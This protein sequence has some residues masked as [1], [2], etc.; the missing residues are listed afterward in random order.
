M[1]QTLTVRNF[2]KHRKLTIDFDPKVTTLVGPS[3]AG[4]SGIIRSLGLICLNNWNKA[5][6]RHGKKALKVQLIVDGKKI[7]REKGNKVNRY[8]FE[9]KELKR[10][11]SSGNSVPP[12]VADLLNTGQENFQKQ[13]DPHF[14]FS[15]TPGQVSKSL[16]KIVD[17]SVIDS[18]LTAATSAVK[19]TKNVLEVCEHRANQAEIAIGDLKWVPEFVK[20]YKQLLALAESRDS[21]AS[22]VRFLRSLIAN[23]RSHSATAEIATEAKLDAKKALGRAKRAREL[24]EQR[25]ELHKL[26]SGLKDLDVLLNTGVPDVGNL[27]YIRKSADKVAENRRELEFLIGELKKAE[28]EEC[29]TGEEVQHAT[30]ELNRSI[31][32]KRCPLCN[33]KLSKQSSSATSTCVTRHRSAG[34]RK[35]KTGTTRCSGI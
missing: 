21:L 11:L 16:N 7:V 27:S 19:A 15:D 2:Q 23:V 3:Q 26:V 18:T 25:K 35:V 5:Y 32:G 12:A 14:W 29:L 24:S 17:L 6:L 1:I 13:F 31:K 10:D 28:K 33:Q 22:S 8:V 30:S 9:G 20:E 4:K 34:L